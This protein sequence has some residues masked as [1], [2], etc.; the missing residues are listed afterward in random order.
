MHVPE[1]T[2]ESFRQAIALGVDAIEFDVHLTRDAQAVVIHDPTLD[3]TT[4]GHGRIAE[5][6]LTEIRAHDAGARFTPDGGRTFPYAGRGLVAPTLAEV[7]ETFPGIP[8]IIEI[9]TPAASPE[10]LRVIRNLGAQ[11]RCIPSSFVDAALDVFHGTG[12]PIGAST[13]HLRDIL[14]RGYLRRPVSA[15][16]F[17]I[18]SMPTHHG[19]LPLPVGGF[20]KILEPLGVPVHVWTVDNPDVARRLWASGVRGILTNDPATMLAAADS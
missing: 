8:C 2:I 17:Q 20:A 3:R 7:L 19:L 4:S 11:D 13:R 15:V 5:L 9:K 16:P 12:I 18:V 1:N 14:W 10:V 6:E